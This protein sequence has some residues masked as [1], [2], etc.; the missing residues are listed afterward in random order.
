MNS[1]AINYEKAWT[2]MNDLEQIA[3]KF[4]HVQSILNAAID[5]IAASDSH[6]AES[7]SAAASS[8]MEELLN[9]FDDKFREAWNQTISK[10]RKEEIVDYWILKI[11]KDSNTNNSYIM[12]SPDMITALNLQEEDVIAWDLTNQ[13][14]VSKVYKIQ[15]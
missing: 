7:L 12:L 6:Q 11:E 4:T 2:A 8:Y 1:M 9:Q 14:N 5:A 3:V 10:I 13:N 15:E